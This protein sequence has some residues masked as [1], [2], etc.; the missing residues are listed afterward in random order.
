MCHSL[1]SFINV[2]SLTDNRHH[3]TIPD[4]R[5]VHVTL[6]GDIPLFDNLLLTNVLYVS[7]FHF[8]LISV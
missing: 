4:G 1:S 3:V 6:V 2:K 7:Q 5:Q 8:N